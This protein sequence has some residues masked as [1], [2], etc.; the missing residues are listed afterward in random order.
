MK[1]WHDLKLNIYNSIHFKNVWLYPRGGTEC[2][3]WNKYDSEI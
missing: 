2:Y 1:I 3:L